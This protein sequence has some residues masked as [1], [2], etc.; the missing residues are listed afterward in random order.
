M[1]I[2]GINSNIYTNTTEAKPVAVVAEL[3]VL[4]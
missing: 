3:I 2:G 1:N 4:E